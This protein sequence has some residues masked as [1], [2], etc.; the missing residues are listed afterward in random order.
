[1][2]GDEVADY[3]LAMDTVYIETSVISHATAWPSKVPEIAV[4]QDQARRWMQE[5]RPKYQVVTSRLVLKEAGRGDS[6]AAK[7][8]LDLLADVPLLPDNLEV[9]EIVKEL[10]TRSLLPPK[11]QVDAV[12]VA[13]AALGGVQYLLTQNCRHIANATMLP[14]LYRLLAELGLS[15]LLICTPAQF[16]G[17]PENVDESNP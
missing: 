14:R 5:Q 2:L 4:L 8:R 7:A 1:M 6:V 9:N 13:T 3:D 11:A 17:D 12:H 16:L 15:G 10:M